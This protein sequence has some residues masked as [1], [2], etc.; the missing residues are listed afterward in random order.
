ML[1]PL[2]PDGR[3]EARWLGVPAPGWVVVQAWP[4]CHAWPRDGG[5]PSWR[6]WFWWRGARIVDTQGWLSLVG[7]SCAVDNSR[8]QLLLASSIAGKRHAGSEPQQQ[9]QGKRV[10]SATPRWL[11]R[12]SGTTAGAAAL[13]RTVSILSG[14]LGSFLLGRRLHREPSQVLRVR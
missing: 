4:S 14:T 10:V 3:W 13:R 9:Q 11:H 2:P 12:C 7:K 1:R 6:R 8:Q 5:E